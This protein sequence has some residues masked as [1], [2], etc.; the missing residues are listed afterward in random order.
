MYAYNIKIDLEENLVR[1]DFHL[2][3]IQYLLSLVKI[4]GQGVPEHHRV[5]RNR[6]ELNLSRVQNKI[7]ELERERFFKAV[8]NVVES[9]RGKH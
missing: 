9:N 7:E 4:D 3:D 8:K 5:T 6:L 2:E 1:A